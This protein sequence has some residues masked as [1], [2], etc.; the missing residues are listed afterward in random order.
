MDIDEA[1]SLLSLLETEQAHLPQS[2]LVRDAPDANLCL[3]P[4]AASGHNT[5]TSDSSSP[6]SSPSHGSPSEA[7]V[8]HSGLLST[9]PSLMLSVNLL[10]RHLGLH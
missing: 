8:Q 10:R 7:S 1:L 2:F 6:P 5:F 3:L 4:S 9:P